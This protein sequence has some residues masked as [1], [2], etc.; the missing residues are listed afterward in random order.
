MT[1]WNGCATKWR[2]WKRR[3]PELKSIHSRADGR[4]ECRFLE[5]VANE[6]RTAAREEVRTPGGKEIGDTK[7]TA[8]AIAL[9]KKPRVATPF[10][11]PKVKAKEAEKD[12]DTDEES[13]ID[14]S[15]TLPFPPPASARDNW[16]TGL[17]STSLYTPPEPKAFDYLTPFEYSKASSQTRRDDQERDK[18]GK[19]SSFKERLA[20]LEEGRDD[21]MLRTA[22]CH[23][24]NRRVGLKSERRG[25]WVI[26]WRSY[27]YLG[28]LAVTWDA[29]YVISAL[30]M[31]CLVSRILGGVLCGEKGDLILGCFG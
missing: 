2:W 8:G 24:I 12:T 16:C 26:L 11:P 15:G 9:Q 13:E 14:E 20:K 3:W 4:T 6:S 18:K 28:F 25:L 5:R 29:K 17:A 10:N 22:I 23:G 21:G 27:L 31:C 19:V 30:N 1:T 7:G